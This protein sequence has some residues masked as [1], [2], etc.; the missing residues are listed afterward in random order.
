M[1]E[2]FAL[3]ATNDRA[4][5]GFRERHGIPLPLDRL[6]VNVNVNLVEQSGIDGDPTR[7]LDTRDLRADVKVEEADLV[8]VRIVLEVGSVAAEDLRPVA[9][10]LQ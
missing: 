6:I 9:R 5:V 7:N 4:L 3:G 2:R 10:P 8:V 1:E